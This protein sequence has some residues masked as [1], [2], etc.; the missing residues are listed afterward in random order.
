MG[1]QFIRQG[2]TKWVV[3]QK[4]GVDVARLPQ[5]VLL[6]QITDHVAF[7]E[8]A[9]PLI[10]DSM[11]NL[12]VS[13]PVRF[14]VEPCPVVKRTLVHLPYRSVNLSVGVRFERSR[15]CVRCLHRPVG[16]LDVGVLARLCVIVWARVVEDGSGWTVKTHVDLHVRGKKTYEVGIRDIVDSVRP[17]YLDVVGTWE[18]SPARCI[19]L[20]ETGAKLKWSL[21][22]ECPNNDG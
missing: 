10:D 8:F 1:P 14:V 4:V 20:A 3:W 22:P 16:D 5:V 18:L 2:Q 11:Q 12:Y 15:L 21:L 7:C 19:F 6:H 17:G 13:L 9:K